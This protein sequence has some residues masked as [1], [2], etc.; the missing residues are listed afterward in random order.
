MKQEKKYHGVV[1]PMV[2]PFK[3]NGKLDEA[4]TLKLS[5]HILDGDTY[6][7]ILGTTGE[8]ASIPF[9]TRVQLVKQVT[10][11]VNQ[12]TIVYTG[13]SDNCFENS[14]T[15]AKKFHDFGIN[16]FVTHLPSYYPLTPDM[17]V[18]Y[19]EKLAEQ[20]PG[21][22]MIYNIK[23]T[24]HMSIPPDVIE[25]LSHHPKIVGLKDS[26]RDFERL[27]TLAKTYATRQ[28]FSLLCGWT[29]QS[30]NTLLL[31]FDGIVPSTGNLIPKKFKQLYDFVIRG[32]NHY[33]QQLQSEIN[34]IAN[35]HQSGM[36]G[37][38][39][40]ATLK[41]MMDELELCEPWV[42]PPLARLSPERENQIKSQMK[43]LGLN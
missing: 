3:E 27:R 26:E 40:I 8:S 29:A 35:I 28:D 33:A 6:P 18:R 21:M 5:E 16:I 11:Y 13:I 2:T 22:I 31:G 41:V 14:L 36:L 12:R 25:K 39:A 20:C 10:E 15:L 37:S 34:P 19:Y 30:L 1:I 7:F 32:D 9:E 24:T 17:M 42:L 43:M 38:E 4:A 23:S